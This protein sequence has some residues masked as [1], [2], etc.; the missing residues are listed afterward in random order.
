MCVDAAIAFVTDGTPVE[1]YIRACQDIR[2]FVTIR[3]VKGGALDQDGH[4]I[5]KA[6]RWYHSTH[7]VGPLTYKVNG[8]TVAR[9]DDTKALMELQVALPGDL[10]YP[11]YIAEAR[12]I[13]QDIGVH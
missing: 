6:V 8:Y 2:Q 1:T 7:V 5:G 4:Y 13:L 3:S 10:D 9:S 11:W 12:S